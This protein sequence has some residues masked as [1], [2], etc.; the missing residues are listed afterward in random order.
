MFAKKLIAIISLFAAAK[1]SSQIESSL[2]LLPVPKNIQVQ[3]GSFMLTDNFN[4]AIQEP[5]PDTIV[6]KAVNRMYQTLNRRSGLYFKQRY[7]SS[8]DTS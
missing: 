8:K 7:I 1:A 5:G 4:V 6:V 3:R 2:N